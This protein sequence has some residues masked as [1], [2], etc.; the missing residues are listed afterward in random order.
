MPATAPD[1]ASITTTANETAGE[2]ATA[3]AM[4]QQSVD[5]FHQLVV[6]FLDALTEVWDDCPHVR[7]T[8]LEYTMACVQSPLAAGAKKDLIVAYYTAMQPYFQRCTAQDESI[9]Q[10]P[11]LA[12][13]TFLAKIK[14]SEKWTPDLHAETKA[15]VWQYLGGLNQYANMFN[16]YS[17]VPPNMLQTIEGMATGIASKIENGDMEM[18]DLNLQNLG[19]QVAENIDMEELNQFAAS[20][21]QNTNGMGQLYSM[22]G[23]MM[24]QMP[25]QQ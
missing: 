4:T 16:L 8:K 13:N 2:S 7:Q 6:Q 24:A 18:K 15:H 19:Q 1:S 5:L 14:F 25:S 23:T 20:M 17:K 10:D 21:M 9:F 3:N 12:S 11:S 22:L